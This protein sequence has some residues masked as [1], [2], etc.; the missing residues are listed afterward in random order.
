[1]KALLDLV[2]AFF[3]WLANRN[4]PEA[5][6]YRKEKQAEGVKDSVDKA[7]IK[8]DEDEVNRHLNRMLGVV[9]VLAVLAGG[10]AHRRTVYIHESD[11]VIFHELNGKPGWWVPE[12]IFG[13]MM[14]KL[15][16]AEAKEK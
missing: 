6:E 3:K 11:K 2:T 1:M 8:R 4:S 7:I 14:N 13:R 5:I 16:E 12:A 9:V 15:A 10:C